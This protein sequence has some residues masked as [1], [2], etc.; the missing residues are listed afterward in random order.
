MQ[1]AF[2]TK[3]WSFPRM[4]GQI[5]Y[6]GIAIFLSTVLIRIQLVESLIDSVLKRPQVVEFSLAHIWLNL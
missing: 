5:L 4:E 6:I 1:P 2:Q 3:F